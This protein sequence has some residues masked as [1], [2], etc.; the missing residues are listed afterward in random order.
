HLVVAK[1]VDSIPI[2]RIEKDFKRQGVPLSRSTLNDLFHRAAEI[3]T[4]LSA[5]LLDRIRARPIVLADETR[6]RML[7]GGNG[8]PKNGFHWTFVAEDEA[9]DADVAFV[10]A[11]DRS[12]ETPRQVLGGTEGTL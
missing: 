3:I 1:C 4:P 2:Y 12:G 8:K 5:R 10:F 6:T 7:D 11:A 9:G